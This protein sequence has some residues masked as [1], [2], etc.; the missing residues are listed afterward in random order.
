MKDLFAE[1]LHSIGQTVLIPTLVILVALFIVALIEIGDILAE[2]FRERRN[3]EKNV[4]GLIMKIQ[5]TDNSQGAEKI[6]E[7]IEESALLARQKKAIREVLDSLKTGTSKE[8]VLALASRILSFEEA[9]Y[10]KQISI[11]NL[12]AKLGPMFGLLG[13]L[14]PLGPGIIALGKGDTETLASSIGIAFDTTIAGLLAASAAIVISG[15]RKRWYNDYMDTLE[16]LLVCIIE[17]VC[18]DDR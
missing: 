3:Y 8:S 13:T 11:T 7:Y 5:N 10:D 17:E 1:I 2:G 4:R 12:V 18:R 16:T 6:W 14:I 15:L 9:H